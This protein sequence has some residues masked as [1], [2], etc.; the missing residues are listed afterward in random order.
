MRQAW[1]EWLNR[2]LRTTTRATQM[3]M[4]IKSIEDLAGLQ[5]SFLKE[6]FDN[7][8]EGSVEILRISGR[9]SEDARRPIEERV[10]QLRNSVEQQHPQEERRA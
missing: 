2:S 7:L 8:L 5:R 6:S 3:M 1:M 4:H 10:G 9:V